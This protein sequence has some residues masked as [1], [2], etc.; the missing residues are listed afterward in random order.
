MEKY[1]DMKRDYKFTI[2]EVVYMVN[3]PEQ[4]AGVV[5]SVTWWGGKVFSYSVV[6]V[7]GEFEVSTLDIREELLTTEKQVS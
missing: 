2:D 1:I 4:N 6:F 3:D 5:I 7:S